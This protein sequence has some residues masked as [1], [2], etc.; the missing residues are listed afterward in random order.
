MTIYEINHIF[1]FF[2]VCMDLKVVVHHLLA[3]GLIL[4]LN[5]ENR[6]LRWIKFHSVL[7]IF[8]YGLVQKNM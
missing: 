1:I 3:I 4:Y 6:E 2:E 7:I 5:Q 8:R